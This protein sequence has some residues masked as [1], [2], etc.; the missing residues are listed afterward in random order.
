VARRVRDRLQRHVFLADHG[1]GNRISASIGL[2]TL[3]DV[4]DT[5]EGLLQAADAAMYRVKVSGKN[6]IHVAGHD[7]TRRPGI[8]EE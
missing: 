4:T 3:P 5:A 1:P 6:G 8:N 2:A 7:E